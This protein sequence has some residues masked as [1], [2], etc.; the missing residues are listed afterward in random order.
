M[1]DYFDK[2]RAFDE[3][4]GV[5]PV[6]P[7]DWDGHFDCLVCGG[8]VDGPEDMWEMCP[9]CG[10]ED[11]PLQRR[12]H[13]E[14]AGPNGGVSLNQAKR[15]VARCGLALPQRECNQEKIRALIESGQLKPD[16][17]YDCDVC[18]CPMPGYFEWHETCPRC[19]WPNNR[20]GWR[21]IPEGRTRWGTLAEARA[22]YEATGTSA[23]ETRQSHG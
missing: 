10:W 12:D 23:P 17:A 4:D 9:H 20:A 2:M 19:A 18:G 11:D 6:K 13:D 8:R 15:N 21:L 5:S 7:I 14:T 16:I 3:W 22:R 1:S